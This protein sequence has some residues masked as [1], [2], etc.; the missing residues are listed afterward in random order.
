MLS[1]NSLS[2]PLQDFK[3]MY[4]ETTSTESEPSNIYY[5]ELLDIE[6]VCTFQEAM[7][8]AQTKLRP[9][10]YYSLYKSQ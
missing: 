9:I 6:F 8:R 4:S 10:S 7:Q 5:M 1:R 3:T 2:T